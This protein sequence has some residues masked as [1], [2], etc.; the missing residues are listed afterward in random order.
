MLASLVLNSYHNEHVFPSINLHPEN[1]HILANA[2]KR[3]SS[4]PSSLAP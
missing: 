2:C 3:S 1:G 4:D